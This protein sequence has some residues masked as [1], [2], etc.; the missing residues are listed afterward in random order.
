MGIKLYQVGQNSPTILANTPGLEGQT[1]KLEAMHKVSEGELDT[2]AQP[3]VILSHTDEPEILELA[4]DNTDP[5]ENHQDNGATPPVNTQTSPP[6]PPL[7][8]ASAASAAP[9]PCPRVEAGNAALQAREGELPDVS[10]LGADYILYGVYQDWV[11]K[12]IGELLDGGIRKIVSGK[13]GGKNLFVCRPNAM[14]HL[15]GNRGRYL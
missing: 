4:D 9:P 15:P 13:R 6:H 5:P 3:T 14:T 10:L 11:H 1:S 12:K 7:E 2:I 8:D